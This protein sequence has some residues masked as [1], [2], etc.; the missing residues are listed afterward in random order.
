MSYATLPRPIGVSIADSLTAEEMSKYFHLPIQEVAQK[1]NICV[2]VLKQHCRRLGIPRWPFRKIQS[3]DKMIAAL[4][5]I[6]KKGTA[7]PSLK[8]ELKMLRDKRS[9]LI[10]T[11]TLVLQDTLHSYKAHQ[12]GS[13]SPFSGMMSPTPLGPPPAVVMSGIP[14]APQPL[15]PSPIMNTNPMISSSLLTAHLPAPFQQALQLSAQP[16]RQSLPAPPAPSR[17]PGGMSVKDLLSP[18]IPPAST[19]PEE[20]TSS[21]NGPFVLPPS[22]TLSPSGSPGTLPS[23]A[24]APAM[25]IASLICL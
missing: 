11:P 25:N 3:L 6:E 21:P 7:T 5:S 9:E 12:R 24:S 4:E 16:A 14:Q 15:L 10:K 20:V 18:E 1:L 19:A 13:P 22:G 17:R 2:T 23:V 8:S